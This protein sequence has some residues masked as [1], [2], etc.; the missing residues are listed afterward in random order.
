[1]AK[2]AR[3]AV[4]MDKQYGNLRPYLS[5]LSCKRIIAISSTIFDRKKFKYGL[6]AK[7]PV[8]KLTPMKINCTEILN[9]KK[10]ISVF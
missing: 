6:P 1:M 9:M 10:K 7:S 4:D 8:K 2:K 3:L 5:M